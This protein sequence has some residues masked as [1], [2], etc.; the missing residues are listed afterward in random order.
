MEF[1]QWLCSI[2]FGVDDN[3]SSHSDNRKNSFLE[4]RE[5]PTYGIYGS[6]GSAEK[7][8]ELILGKQTQ[9]LFEFAL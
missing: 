4:L 8:L 1:W 7:S 2:I 3:S 9:K 6:F 5:C